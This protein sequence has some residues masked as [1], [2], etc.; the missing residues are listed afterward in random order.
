MGCFYTNLTVVNHKDESRTV[1]VWEV[2]VDTG[3]EAT[4][5]P[6]ELLEK[7]GVERRKKDQSFQMANGQIITR[8]VGYAIIQLGEY[9]TT[10]EVVF[11][12]VGDLPLLGAR[13]MEGFNVR[14]DPVSKRL[15]AAGPIPVASNL[16]TN[17]EK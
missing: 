10:D 13:T 1:D 4:W 16:Q 14:V 12:E 6:R 3:A 8:G 2:L 9:E 17:S 11:A 7:I 5:I 15:V